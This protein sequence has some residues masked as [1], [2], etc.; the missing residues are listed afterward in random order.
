MRAHEADV[1]IVGSG[2][3][4]V[5]AAWP[6]VTAGARVLMLDASTPAATPAPPWRHRTDPGHWQTRFGSDLSAVEPVADRSPK[7]A[8]P[9]ARTTL[10]GYHDRLG[11][12]SDGFFAAGTLGQGGLSTIWGALAAPLTAAERADIPV[13]AADLDGAYAR[14]GRRIGL[15]RPVPPDSRAAR[16]ILDAQG[17]RG[18]GPDVTF[19]PAPNAVL[20]APLGDREACN[21]CGLCLYGC[22]RG[23]IYSSALEM[24]LLA[25]HGN[26]AYRPGHL[27]RAV[28]ADPA[29]HRVVAETRDG[30]V[31]LTAPQVVLAA[32][33]VATTG[34]A[35]ARLG[36][37]GQPVRLLSNPAA[38]TAFVVPGL[39]GLPLPERAFGLGQLFYHLG[40]AAGVLYGADTL[41][42]DILA[43]RLP[44]GRPFALRVSRALAPALLLATCYRPGSESRNTATLVSGGRWPTLALAG[45][46]TAEAAAGLRASLSRLG[47]GLRRL[48]ALRL[49][50]ST[51]I[52]E[53]GADAHYAGTLPMG[54]PGPAATT[55]DG[56]LVGVPGLFV[57]DGAALPTLPATHPTLTIMA[58]ADRIGHGLAGRMPAA[59]RLRRTA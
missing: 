59:S 48:G 39:V 57:A 44:V 14:V 16:R 12:G 56:E 47:R 51:S 23:S 50:G 13:P 37:L 28:A 36:L 29:G 46:P 49:P 55:A 19:A 58:N 53:P 2:P 10:H 24:P 34:L 26:F 35:L 1:I 21:R 38:A 6:L 15:S 52:L 43:E 25:R 40:D 31:S 5:S 41:P 7:F 18:S 17:R 3:A 11:I 42:V 20:A 27:V 22:G 8:T 33:T 45:E 32:G 30:M 9:L 54:G 4:G